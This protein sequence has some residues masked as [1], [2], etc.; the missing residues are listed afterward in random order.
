VFVTF[1][2]EELGLLG[3]TYYV[4]NPRVPLDRTGRHAQPRHGGPA[5]RPDHGERARCGAGVGQRGEGRRGRSPCHRGETVSGRR[6]RGLERRHVVC[7]QRI[8][9][10]GFFSGFHSDYHR[11]T[12]DWPLIEPAGAA[13]VATLALELASRLS[14]A[15][16]AEYVAPVQAAHGPS[17]GDPGSVGGYGPYFGSVPDFGEQESGVK[18]AEV[19]ENSPAGKAGLR[20]GDVMVSF[21]GKPVKTLFD[22][23]F[24]LREKK[25]G[26]R[27]RSDRQTQRAAAHRQGAADHATLKPA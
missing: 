12:D 10:I 23:T 4:N 18:F 22:F 15:E 11:P 25:A 5:A 7:A 19:R 9:S 26:R 13:G 8:P 24:L 14:G 21:D 27:G 3:S 20:G 16:R 17:G 6:R 2:G 1:A